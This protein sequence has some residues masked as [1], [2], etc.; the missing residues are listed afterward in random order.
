MA[1]TA[2]H[3]YISKE[4]GDKLREEIFLKD[5]TV[6]E[7]STKNINHSFTVSWETSLVSFLL[8][9]H[10]F[11]VTVSNAFLG[12]IEMFVLCTCV[13]VYM[14]TG[15]GYCLV[16]DWSFTTG[17]SWVWHWLSHTYAR[18]HTHTHTF[19]YV[20]IHRYIHTYMH[21]LIHAHTLLYSYV[22]SHIL[23]RTLAYRFYVHVC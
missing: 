8:F 19:T 17:L 6:A 13:H 20:H 11:C 23:T 15:S 16:H 21:S 4:K 10:A 5:V 1:V 2:D 7:N 18:T 3:L 14:C 22:H 9:F 12:E